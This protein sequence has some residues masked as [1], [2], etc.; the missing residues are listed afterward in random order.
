MKKMTILL[1]VLALSSCKD[2]PSQPTSQVE[3]SVKVAPLLGDIRNPDTII[4]EV[5]NHG[6]TDNYRM[7]GCGYWAH[8]MV[9][10]ILG[11]DSSEVYLSDPRIRPLCLDQVVPFLPGEKFTGV[12]QFNGKLFNSSGNQFDAQSGTY[13]VIVRFWVSSV[14]DFTGGGVIERRASFQW[15]AK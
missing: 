13:M 6:T 8:G 1:F 4:A 11:P 3:L 2:A 10:G 7:D 15:S 12:A 14:R 5:I 9:L